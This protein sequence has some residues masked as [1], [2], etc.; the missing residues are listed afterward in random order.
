MDDARLAVRDLVERRR[1]EISYEYDRE[2]PLWAKAARK[3]MIAS[4]T[5]FVGVTGMV[6]LGPWAHR[7]PRHLDRL[8]RPVARDVRPADAA[9]RSPPH[10]GSRGGVAAEVLEQSLRALVRE[11]RASRSQAPRDAGR[12]HLP[13]DRAGDQPRGRHLVRLAAQAISAR[14][15]GSTAAH[16][17]TG[18][19][20]AAYAQDGRRTQRR[21]RRAGERGAAAQSSAL[22]GDPA[23]SAQA[24]AREQ[25]RDDLAARRD[26]A[27]NRLAAA[28]AALEG[29]RLNLLRLKA[30]IGTVS[31]LTADLSG[32]AGYGGRAG[33]RRPAREEVE[34]L[35]APPAQPPA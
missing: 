14:A 23:A 20:R 22:R 24:A 6:A 15:E 35:L 33:S 32:A 18:A 7:D 31:E 1:E 28:V 26:E 10:P 25:L 12:A 13:S 19:R 16:G 9:T 11:D 2:P 27:A 4:G 8:G 17:A 5:V 30:G 29:I 21:A 34:A 3:L